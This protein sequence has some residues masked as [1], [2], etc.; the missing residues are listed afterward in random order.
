M[1]YAGI[2]VLVVFALATAFSFM[3][4]KSKRIAAEDHAASNARVLREYKRLAIYHPE[5][6]IDNPRTT[7]RKA[8][9]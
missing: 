4:A 5:K 1:E 3:H 2:G 7:Q 9:R 6:I 8:P